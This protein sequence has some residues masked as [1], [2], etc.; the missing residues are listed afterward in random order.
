MSDA[1]P[2]REF[3]EHLLDSVLNEPDE[4]ELRAYD[5]DTPRG[6]RLFVELL[7]S[8]DDRDLLDANGGRI[9]AAIATAFDAFGSKHQTRTTFELADLDGD[10]Y[11]DDPEEGGD[12]SDDDS[13]DGDSDDGDSDDE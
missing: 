4:A 12:G 7:P 9:C 8:D 6:E 1:S 11:E 10:D 2:Q 3:L 5:K 13:D